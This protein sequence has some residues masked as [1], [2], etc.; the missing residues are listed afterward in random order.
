MT[1]ATLH[2]KL[3][4]P[5][6]ADVRAESVVDSES[7]FNGLYETRQDLR[8][9]GIAEG[10]IQCDGTLTVAN[11]ARVKAKVTASNMTIAGDLEGEVV[12]QGVFEITPTGQVQATVQAHRLVV[13][14]GGFFEGDFHMITDAS[15]IKDVSRPAAKRAIPEPPERVAPPPPPPPARDKSPRERPGNGG[16]PGKLLSSDEWWQKMGATPP[17]DDSEPSTS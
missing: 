7:H 10:E 4:T 3:A 11:G 15:G 14:E 8:I 6:E 12:C 16:Q 9:E 5:A 13:Q 1:I 2:K 17:A